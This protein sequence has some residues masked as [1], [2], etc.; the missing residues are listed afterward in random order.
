MTSPRLSRQLLLDELADLE[1]YRALRPG[2]TGE[3]AKVLDGF[4]QTEI[5]H[6]AFWREHS[7][8]TD[9]APGFSGRLRNTILRFAV[10]LFGASAAFLILE[11]VEVHGVRKY[12]R[13]WESVKDL[14]VRKGLETIL[15]DEIQHED[16]AVMGG[17]SRSLSPETVRNAFLGFNDGSVEILG[18]VSGFAAAFSYNPALVVI[19][20]LTVSVAGSISMAAGAFLST[21]SEQEVQALEEGKR[22]FIARE[23]FSGEKEVETPSSPWRASA[24]V[25]TSYLIGAAVPVLP[26]I[27]GA[28]QPYWSIGFSG[29]LILLVSGVL[30]FLSGMGIVKRIL[31]NT[32]VLFAAV[33][34]SYV[35]GLGAHAVFGV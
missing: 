3:L 23:N 2:A 25:G 20:G 14:E 19:S 7:G 17:R 22:R 5:R 30:A 31:L 27:L 11:A 9:Q 33:G 15:T 29:L 6:A 1:L 24:L 12:L 32:G 8:F 28:R 4:I 35:V 13:L 34:I 18:A 21:H 16:E 26:F 10:F